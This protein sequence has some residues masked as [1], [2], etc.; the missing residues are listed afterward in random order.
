ME[1]SKCVTRVTWKCPEAVCDV[2]SIESKYEVCLD[3]RAGAF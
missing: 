2:V 1:W 3:E